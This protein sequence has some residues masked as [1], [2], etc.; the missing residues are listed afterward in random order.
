MIDFAFQSQA[1]IPEWRQGLS[2]VSES[3]KPVVAHTLPVPL[4]TTDPAPLK[5]TLG[6]G[7][8]HVHTATWEHS[9]KTQLYRQAN[10]RR[11]D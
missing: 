10:R 9:I 3:A 7:T 8:H 11:E 5:L 6:T 4:H 2:E 1:R